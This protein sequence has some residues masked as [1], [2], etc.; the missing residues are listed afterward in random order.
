MSVWCRPIAIGCLGVRNASRW[1]PWFADSSQL[2]FFTDEGLI[3]SS[4]DGRHRRVVLHTREPA[5]LAVPSPDGRLIAYATF[6]S[7]PAAPNAMG[8]LP[9]WNCTGIWVVGTQVSAEPVRVAGPS[10]ESTLFNTSDVPVQRV[11]LRPKNPGSWNR[12]AYVGG[13]PVNLRRAA[14]R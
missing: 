3:V 13:D 1:D 10:P 11:Y 12:Y 7:R 6:A 4:P 8:N 5:G 2:A 9:V 14:H